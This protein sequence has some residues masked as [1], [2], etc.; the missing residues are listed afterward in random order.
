MY[1]RTRLLRGVG[2]RYSRNVEYQ[3]RKTTCLHGIEAEHGIEGRGE[4]RGWFGSCQGFQEIVVEEV[5]RCF[6]FLVKS[7]KYT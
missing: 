5:R 4:G 3:N 7:V 6:W 1:L 2:W